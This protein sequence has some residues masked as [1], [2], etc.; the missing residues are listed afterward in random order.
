MLKGIRLSRRFRTQRTS[1]FN[2]HL[3][4]DRLPPKKTHVYWSVLTASDLLHML[5]ELHTKSYGQISL[6][7]MVIV[8]TYLSL[9]IEY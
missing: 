6:L 5:T 9:Q 8:I 3:E 2:P 7:C 4:T 1:L